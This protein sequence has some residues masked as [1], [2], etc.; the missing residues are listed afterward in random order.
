MLVCTTLPTRTQLSELKYHKHVPL[1]DSALKT[2][3]L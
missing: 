3:K 2:I 1:L